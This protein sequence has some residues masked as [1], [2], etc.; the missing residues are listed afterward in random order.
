MEPQSPRLQ[1]ANLKQ[2]EKGEKNKT[3]EI[4]AGGAASVLR[5]LSGSDR[6]GVSKAVD[7]NVLEKKAKRTEMLSGKVGL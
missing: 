7:K 5:S 3:I 1:A 4:T 2:K 6:M